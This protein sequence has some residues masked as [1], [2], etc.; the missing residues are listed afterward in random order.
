MP[1]DHPLLRRVQR[2]ISEEIGLDESEI[3]LGSTIVD[4]LGADSLDCVEIVMR[5]EEEFGIDIDDE[6]AE[7]F[8]RVS[9]LVTYLEAVA[10]VKA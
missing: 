9:D 4:D 1:T 8:V 3:T 5:C 10:K 6:E 7:T 2:L